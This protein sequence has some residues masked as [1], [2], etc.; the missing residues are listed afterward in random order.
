MCGIIGEF[1]N[2]FSFNDNSRRG[3]ITEALTCG[4]VRGHDSTGILAVKRNNP[5][6]VFT[7]KKA[8]AGPDFVQLNKYEKFLSEIP[9]YRFV[10]GHNRWATKGGVSSKTAHPFTNGNISLVHNGTL[11]W[12]EN[13]NTKD[14][15]TVDSEAI[16]AAFNENGARETIK[17]LNGAYALVWYDSD[18]EKMYMVRNKE[19]PLYYATVKDSD[20]IIFA[21]EYGML[22]WL[23]NRNG[24]KIKEIY[25]VE[26]DVL[27]EF[28][29]N[30]ETDVVKTPV[31]TY[32]PYKAPANTN[33]N[34]VS[35]FGKHEKRQR[36][37]LAK[38]GLTKGDWTDIVP[39]SWE[40]YNSRQDRGAF[41]CTSV[42][43]IHAEFK[44]HGVPQDE[45]TLGTVISGAISSYVQRTG[46]Q[47]DQVLIKDALDTGLTEKEWVEWEAEE[48]AKEALGTDLAVIDVDAIIDTEWV[49]GPSGVAIPVDEFE[50]LTKH[51]CAQC[52]GNITIEDDETMSWTVNND[53]ICPSC[54]KANDDAGIHMALH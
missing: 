45:F 39:V 8:V 13:L 44:V 22:A 30:L 20:T 26:V 54:T 48:A 19:R 34:N 9:S 11:T 29:K 2:N 5:K 50:E 43:G 3:F 37:Q 40:P 24:Y 46:Q 7:Y 32:T 15:Y 10:V 51:G 35:S 33:N 23:G 25:D 1:N 6:E 17:K 27:H 38:L 18:K 49:D 14:K 4:V 12:H 21:S 42:Y 41:L 31:E 28:D 47:L 53:P 16:C 36:N 52:S